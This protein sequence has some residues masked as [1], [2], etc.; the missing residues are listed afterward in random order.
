MFVAL[1]DEKSKK[2]DEKGAKLLYRKVIA[3]LRDCEERYKGLLD[4]I[5]TAGLARRLQSAL[6]KLKSEVRHR[7]RL[8]AELLTAVESE[9]ER[10]GQD[11]HDDLCQHLG[12]T[13]IMTSVIA[14]RIGRKDSRTGAELHEVARL[15]NDTIDSCRMIARG[16][17]PVT[18]AAKGLPGALDE[19]AERMPVSINFQ[20]P[21]GTRIM[22]EPATA[23]HLYRIIEET[24]GNAVKHSGA[25]DIAVELDVVGGR[26]V[27]VV[28]DN[29]KGFKQNSGSD[30]MGLRNIHYRAGV[31]GAE[32]KIEPRKGGGTRLSCK[33]PRSK[34]AI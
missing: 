23:L 34:E 20:W 30:G 8:E 21:Q 13:A 5:S 28:E 18:L 10:I 2:R 12:A 25:K 14:T 31:I 11:L 33:L 22:L 26:T 27:L 32:L 16:L 17:H 4:S 24:V 29:G 3:D 19:L 6:S 15:I 9:R 1:G 7:R